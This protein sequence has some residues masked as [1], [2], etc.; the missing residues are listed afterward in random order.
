MTD[1]RLSKKRLLEELEKVR[2]QAGILHDTIAQRELEL[3]ALLTASRSISEFSS[4]QEA[5]QTIFDIGKELI[6]AS[7]GYIALLSDDASENEVVFLDAGGLPCSVDPLLPMPIRGLRAEVY[8]TGRAVF[9]NDFMNSEWLPLMPDGHVT[10]KNVLFAPLAVDERVIGILGLANKERDFD[11]GDV[12]MA[13]AFGDLA[14]IALSNYQTYKS[15]E[16]SEERLRFVAQSATD[17]IITADGSGMI[18][19]WNNSAGQIFG[20]DAAEVMG[21][22][23]E[24]LMPDR[25]RGQHRQALQR[26]LDTGIPRIIGKTVELFGVRSDGS[27]FPI[28]LSLSTWKTDDGVFF[29]GIIRDTT[30]RKKSEQLSKALN[31]IN[32]AM[33]ATLD[34][35]LIARAAMIEASRVLDSSRAFMASP[36]GDGWSVSITHGFP[37]AFM[38]TRLNEQESAVMAAVIEGGVSTSSMDIIT[39]G[40]MENFSRHEIDSLL[41][42]PLQTREEALGVLAI[43]YQPLY[44]G[45]SHLDLE[46]A[47]RLS[48]SLSL[49]LKNAILYSNEL[50]SR[51]VCQN[52][53]SQLA[54]LHRVGLALNRETDKYKLLRTVLKA[55]AELTSASI[56]IMT[57]VQDSKTSVVA[58]H[59]AP[60]SD[61]QC[62]IEG[63]ILLLHQR[64][65]R[66]AE[67]RDVIRFGEDTTFEA[68][69][70]GHLALR[71]LIIGIIRDTLGRMKGF[72]MLSDKV[73]GAEFNAADEEIITLLAAQS[74]VALVSAE[75][76]EREHVVA[77]TLQSA[78][79]P[80]PPHREDIDVGLLYQSAGALGR[81]GGDFYDFVE[82]DNGMVAVVIGDVCGK[83][84]GAATYTAMIKYMLRAY[85]GENMLPGDCLTRL[86]RN[87]HNQVS[88]EKFV[89]VCLLMID[90]SAGTIYYSS[91]GH[92]PPVLRQGG[93]TNML[94]AH[95]AV[96]LGVIPD[97][98]FLT[99][100]LSLAG[101]ETLV[102]YTDGLLD[103]RPDDGAPFGDQRIINVIARSHNLPAQSMAQALVD[104]AI[105]YSGDALRD[106]IALLVVRLIGQEQ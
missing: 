62:M 90:M 69:P 39:R 19:S 18:V 6:G 43:D 16:E 85:L 64:I 82:L 94:S 99:T 42:I 87:V 76:F 74:S 72:F 40:G 57:L 71:G 28:D 32:E 89:T 34:V 10:L 67:N 15:L 106:D 60:W 75:N 103:A 95:P 7:S 105:I 86:N 52:Y 45:T 48:I 55:A 37:D 26:Y 58:S 51:S 66:L 73:D 27:E 101:A 13:T 11:E 53:A 61:Q 65:S 96:P 24:M 56:G 35:D 100:Q 20:Y 9:D 50:E 63:D 79:L 47:D 1:K 54:V 23:I 21:K 92:P 38:G 36:H 68:L 17:A 12:R 41:L 2:E 49:S 97:Q 104:S 46:F 78:L 91:A 70:D 83:G 88:I 59:Y 30:A 3:A 77:E 80:D 8:A 81:I 25:F 102:M 33:S 93:S 4:F 5:A 31:N 98:R 84:L 14:A 29:T 22:Q 44:G